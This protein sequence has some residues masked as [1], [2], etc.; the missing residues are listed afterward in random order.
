VAVE[1]YIFTHEKYTE[2]REGNIYNNQNIKQ[3]KNQKNNLGLGNNKAARFH[4]N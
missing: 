4:P 3:N 2:Y 1:Q